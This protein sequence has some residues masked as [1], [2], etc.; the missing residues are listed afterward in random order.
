MS[1]YRGAGANE[2]ESL[3]S[4]AGDRSANYASLHPGYEAKLAFG[5]TAA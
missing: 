4:F 5:P 1:R 2:N 3:L